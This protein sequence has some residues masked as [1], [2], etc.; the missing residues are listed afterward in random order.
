V[1]LPR[2]RTHQMKE[3]PEFFDIT[4]RLRRLIDEAQGSAPEG[5]R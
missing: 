3:W 4:R 5:D 1:G 2:P